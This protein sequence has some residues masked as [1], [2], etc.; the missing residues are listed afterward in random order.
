[1]LKRTI[2]PFKWETNDHLFTGSLK[3]QYNRVQKRK[4]FEKKHIAT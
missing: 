4:T 3:A 1:M 2:K